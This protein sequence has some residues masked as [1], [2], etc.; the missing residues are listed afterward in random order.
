MSEQ[1]TEER[2]LEDLDL[3][4]TIEG[5]Q[6]LKKEVEAKEKAFKESIAEDKAAIEILASTILDKF[7]QLKITSVKMDIGTPYVSKRTSAKVESPDEFFNFVLETGRTELLEARA[8]TKA[9]EEFIETSK[10]P[11]PGVK[12]EI[13][14]RLNFRSKS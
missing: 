13:T 7:H 9:V 5:W 4:E 6:Q 3:T 2:Y 11:P 1:G 10:V 8:S 12:V 14:E